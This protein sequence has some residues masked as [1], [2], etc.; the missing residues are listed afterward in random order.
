MFE[1]GETATP[2][3]LGGRVKT[4]LV[5]AGRV[6]ALLWIALSL[7][8]AAM[9]LVGSGPQIVDLATT[10]TVFGIWSVLAVLD[11]LFAL[12]AILGVGVA[13]VRRKLLLA[14]LFSLV[15]WPVGFVIEASRCDYPACRSMAWAALPAWTGDW[16]IRLRPVTDPRE[17]ENIASAALDKVVSGYSAY[18]P[19]RFDD[20]W[21]V[22]TINGDGWPGPSAVRIDT[23]TAA[24][25]FVPC[26]ADRMLCGM[27]RPVMSQAGQ[28]FSNARW[29]L[30]MSFPAGRAVCIARPYEEARRDEAR[31]FYAMIRDADTPC[32]IVDPS[33][34]LG[35]EALT[36]RTV[37]EARQ[38]PCKPLSPA[39]LKA[40]GGAAPGFAGRQSVACE[41]VTEDQIA[42]SVFAFAEPGSGA[43][44]TLY[45]A[46]V[47]TDPAHLPEDAREF[48]TFLRTARLPPPSR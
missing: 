44:T 24:T 39:R 8:L 25:R 3:G 46:W 38:E 28:V 30:S 40:F 31:G 15:A 4:V 18:Y 10:E 21:I 14:L 47:L 35:L 16:S 2:D 37:T 29:G 13:L 17:A 19:K 33:R 34:T 11:V 48:E 42:V 41:E 7:L 1:R 23:R 43:P 36:A 32:D 45:E 9:S 6:L 26:P 5:W 20:H 12:A 27:E 22:P